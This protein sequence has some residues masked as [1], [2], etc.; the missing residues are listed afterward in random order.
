MY[1]LW[2]LLI[3]GVQKSVVDCCS[4]APVLMLEKQRKEESLHSFFVGI[5]SKLVHIVFELKNRNLELPLFI[6]LQSYFY[7]FFMSHLSS[8]CDGSGS[9][10]LPHNNTWTKQCTPAE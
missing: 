8:R 1:A 9:A 7:H 10:R 3:R 2:H 4:P 5:E 6:Y